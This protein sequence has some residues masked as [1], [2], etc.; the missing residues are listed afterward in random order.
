MLVIDKEKFTPQVVKEI[1][2]W[3]QELEPSVNMT[4]SILSAFLLPNQHRVDEDGEI[5]EVKLETM[6]KYVFYLILRPLTE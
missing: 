5:I 1:I 6:T 2:K 3:N 4:Q